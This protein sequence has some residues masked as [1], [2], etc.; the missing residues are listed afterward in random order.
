MKFIW[1]TDCVEVLCQLWREGH[2]S[3]DIARY[4]TRT[5]Q[6]PV[7]RNSIMGKVHRLQIQR[8]APAI[9]RQP[10]SQTP[11]TPHGKPLPPV[12]ARFQSTWTEDQDRKFKEMYQAGF[13]DQQI[14]N[15]INMSKS[16]VQKRRTKL[17]MVTK[18]FKKKAH[19]KP[20]RAFISDRKKALLRAN[21]KTQAVR[22]EQLGPRDCRWATNDPVRGADFAFC[23]REVEKGRS[24]CSDHC[25]IAYRPVEDA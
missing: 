11:Q 20:K 3:G 7:T 13:S 5:Y 2:T 15:E 4:F 12:G 25:A 18:Q 21:A 24:Y 9:P 8:N 14:A 22:I 10:T 16:A 19:S 23:G 1:T 6:T 17:G